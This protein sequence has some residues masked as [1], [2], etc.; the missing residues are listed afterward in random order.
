MKLIGLMSGTSLDGLDICE[1]DFYEQNNS[2]KYHLGSSETISYSIDWINKLKN[3][4]CLPVDEFLELHIQ[5]GEL[6]GKF[7][8]EFIRKNNL[9]NIE[10]ISS[11]GHTIF[12]QPKRKITFQL[13]CGTSIFLTTGIKTVHDFRTQDVLLGGQGAPFVPIGDEL[14]FS[15]YDACL[16]LGG[17]SNISFKIDNQRV[18]FDISPAN[19]ILNLIAQ[20]FD[21]EYDK[22]G[23][24]AKKYSINHELIQ[25]LNNL[26]FYQNKFPKSLGIE[27]LQ[28]EVLPILKNYS[29]E[30]KISTLTE[31]IAQQISNVINFNH[32]KNVLVTGGGAKNMFLIDL[33]NFK[34]ENKLVLPTEKLIDFKEALIFAFLGFLK[35]QG[36]NNVL[37]SVTGAKQDHSSGRIN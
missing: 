14:L 6:L 3:A 26:D 16:N 7:V 27:W 21:L 20:E 10:A 34:T 22:N 36:K 13:G 31:H 1:V 8:N 28:K 25:K 4:F 37:K 32:F 33:I 29:K 12:H 30:E 2:Y 19:S 18:G 9:Q 5:Y 35:I 11:H 24:L 23:N 17:F 15:D